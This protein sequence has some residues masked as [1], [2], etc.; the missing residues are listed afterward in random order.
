MFGFLEKDDIDFL[1]LALEYAKR[2]FLESESY[3]R[4]KKED[5]AKVEELKQKLLLVKAEL[6]I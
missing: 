6:E 2:N 3:P 4:Q 5:L 1:L